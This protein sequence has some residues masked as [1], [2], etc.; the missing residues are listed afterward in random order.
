MENCN[1]NQNKTNGYCMYVHL[2]SGSSYTYVQCIHTYVRTSLPL[3]HAWWPVSPSLVVCYLLCTSCPLW[4]KQ[5]G[6]TYVHMYIPCICT[7]VYVSWQTGSRGYVAGQ[8]RLDL[9]SYCVHA[10]VYTYV[11]ILIV[12]MYVHVHTWMREE[13]RST[14]SWVGT[15]TGQADS[16]PAWQCFTYT[17]HTEGRNGG[18]SKACSTHV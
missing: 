12:H 13:D 6:G 1:G 4:Y 18:N 3:L 14:V 17:Y 16:Q 15:T 2:H 10:S 7:H 5:Q 8:T 9:R 11:R